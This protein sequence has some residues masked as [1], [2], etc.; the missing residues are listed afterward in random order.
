MP[1]RNVNYALNLNY[2]IYCK[3]QSILDIYIGRTT[4]FTLR[5]SQHK[6][7]SSKNN[8][9]QAFLYECINTNG[10]W[11]N[12]IMEKIEDYPC[13]NSV[14]ACKREQYWINTLQATLNFVIEFET[15]N[16]YKRDWY[17]KQRGKIAERRLATKKVVVRNR[18]QE[19]M[20]QTK[21]YWITIYYVNTNPDWYKNNKKHWAKIQK[22][23]QKRLNKIDILKLI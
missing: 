19:L 14:E 22:K 2:K 1:P 7:D 12:W 16:L 23:R 5:K 15:T 8:Q 20:R 21:N 6:T 10:G 18:E 3:N 4:N 11:S 13:E 9:T 17:F